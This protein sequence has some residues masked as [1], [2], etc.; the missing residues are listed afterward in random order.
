MQEF[1][2]RSSFGSQE[3]EVIDQQAIAL[4]E[5]LAKGAQLTIAHCLNKAVGKVFCRHVTR[6]SVRLLLAQTNVNALEKVGL[7]TA[8]GPVQHERVYALARRLDKAHRGG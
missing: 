6:A 7:A 1:F 4:T 8:N 3:I 2:L 5:I